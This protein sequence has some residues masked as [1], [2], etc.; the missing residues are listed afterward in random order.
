MRRAGLPTLAIGHRINPYKYRCE[1]PP[2]TSSIRMFSGRGSS[3]SSL[4]PEAVS[5]TYRFAESLVSIMRAYHDLEASA[6]RTYPPRRLGLE[7]SGSLPYAHDPKGRKFRLLTLGSVRHHTLPDDGV[8]RIGEQA[9]R[10]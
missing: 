4:T 5:I 8:E 3:R 7:Q 2:A 10:A 9:A 1:S 6:A